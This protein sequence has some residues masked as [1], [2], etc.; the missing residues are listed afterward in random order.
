MDLSDTKQP[1]LVSSAYFTK[2]KNLVIDW[3]RAEASKE[4]GRIL[5]LLQLVINVVQLVRV[6]L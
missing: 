2:A 1:V 5:V 4:V 3:T 6:V